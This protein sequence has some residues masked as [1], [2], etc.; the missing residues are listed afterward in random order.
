[1]TWSAFSLLWAFLVLVALGAPRQDSSQESGT[2]VFDVKNYSS[3]VKLPEKSRKALEHGGVVWGM[4][5]KTL[6]VSLVG[7]Q[8]VKADLPYLTR[9]GEQKTLQLKPGQYAITCIGWEFDSTSQD[10]EKALSKSAFFNQDVVTFAVTAGK[11]TTL[12]VLPVFESKSQWHALTKLTVYLPDL[13]VK[14]WED[15]AE[16]GGTVINTRNAKSVPWD[17]YH[18]P[19][20]F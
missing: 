11:T 6:V 9:F 20:K 17:D 10:V 15:G 19:L 5:D 12:D 14:V 18:G 3:G 13:N 7:K 1:M 2:L 16:K 4:D 8:F